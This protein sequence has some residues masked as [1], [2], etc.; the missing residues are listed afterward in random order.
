MKWLR[1]VEKHMGKGE[2]RCVGVKILVTWIIYWYYDFSKHTCSKPGLICP[3][4][5]MSVWRPGS[6]DVIILLLMPPLVMGRT[7]YHVMT[8][9]S[10]PWL[11]RSLN[12]LLWL[13]DQI[14]NVLTD[15]TPVSFMKPSLSSL[16]KLSPFCLNS[17]LWWPHSVLWL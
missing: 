13:P 4:G 15:L 12:R 8:F 17:R 5:N 2:N 10:H 9:V 16:C 11:Y 6:P 7:C 3:Y 14:L 1:T